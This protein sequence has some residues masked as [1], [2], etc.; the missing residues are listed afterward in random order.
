M[1]DELK[2]Y[3]AMANG[4]TEM[5]R[6]QAT[7]AARQ[8]IAQ[9]MVLAARGTATDA[10][11]NEVADELMETVRA[12]REALQEM[13][14][15]S[16]QAAMGALGFAHVDE[17]AAVRKHVD[18]LEGQLAALRTEVEALKAELDA[19]TGSKKS[20]T[21]KGAPKASKKSS[22]KKSSSKKSAAAEGAS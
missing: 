5:A 3:L 15:D 14:D 19:A 4:L 10:D 6:Q 2:P 7:E 11:V 9:G 8:L 13:V 20:G 21:A 22:S 12:N 17:V 1:L 18:R 16:V